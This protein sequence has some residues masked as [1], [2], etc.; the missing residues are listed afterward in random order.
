[1]ILAGAVGVTS[2]AVPFEYLMNI[3]VTAELYGNVDNG[4]CNGRV[5][6]AASSQASAI[7]C[8]L[9]YAAGGPNLVL[10]GH[11]TVKES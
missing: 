6:S 7:I 1:M 11:P 4:T 8:S 5:V 3:R 2:I 9:L 10:A